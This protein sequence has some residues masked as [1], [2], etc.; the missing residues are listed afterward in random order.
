MLYYSTGRR[1]TSSAR[2]FMKLGN[3][4]ILVNNILLSEY[5]NYEIK[6]LIICKPLFLIKNS[7]DI[8]KFNFYITV[9]GGGLSGQAIAIRHGISRV[10]LKYDNN[11]RKKFKYYGFITRDSR[12]VERKKYGFRKSRCRPQYS[13]R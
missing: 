9:K 3:G 6:K 11:L 4:K 5:F 8:N 7:D 2:V 1:K 13:K 12:K 10:L